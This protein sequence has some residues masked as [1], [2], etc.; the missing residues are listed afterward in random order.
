MYVAYQVPTFKPQP[1]ETHETMKVSGNEITNDDALRAEVNKRT[2]MAVADSEARVINALRTGNMSSLSDKMSVLI[3]SQSNMKKNRW[4][5]QLTM[6]GSNGAKLAKVDLKQRMQRRAKF[7][8]ED[9]KVEVRVIKADENIRSKFA[10]QNQVGK[11]KVGGKS[12]YKR[13]YTFEE[14]FIE[15]PDLFMIDDISEMTIEKRVKSVYVTHSIPNFVLVS[16]DT[17]KE[18]PPILLLHGAKTSSATWEKIGTTAAL[19]KEGFDVYTVDL[20]GYG[21]SEGKVDA[22]LRKK[23]LKGLIA[24]LNLEK[25]FLVAPDISGGYAVPFIAEFGT[26]LTGMVQIATA[27]AVRM[28]QPSKWQRIAAATWTTYIYGE[29]DT[30]ISAFAPQFFKDAPSVEMHM[31]KG[32][33]SY[34][35]KPRQF[36]QL[37]LAFLNKA[38]HYDVANK[39]KLDA[40]NRALGTKRRQPKGMGQGMGQ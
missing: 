35:D 30:A 3:K 21:R 19:V 7:D 40:K 27:G 24:K 14:M 34:I 32:V 17:K 36:N 5:A 20:P 11:A 23:F 33:T 8:V 38:V 26:N 37:L 1:I 28:M 2:L 39:P 10:K 25:P 29:L 13:N 16:K 6:G 9:E 4:L 18:A 31:M 12:M 15:H 22:P